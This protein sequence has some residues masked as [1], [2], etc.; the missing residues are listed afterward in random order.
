MSRKRRLL[1]RSCFA[2]A[3]ILFA[4]AALACGEDKKIGDEKIL[5]FQEQ[6]EG[7]RLG[8]SAE[9]PDPTEASS[10]PPAPAPPPAQASR[11]APPNHQFFEVGLVASSPYFE[12]GND[13]TMSVGATLRVTNKDNT[14]ERQI[15]SFTAEDGSFDSGPLKPGQTWTYRFKGPGK[16]RVIDRDAPFI[17]ATIEAR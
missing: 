14:P 10:P 1:A 13:M 17:Y 8:G 4:L 2:L 16:W 11:S 9:S 5:D 7:G 3:V 15:R 6:K 12:P